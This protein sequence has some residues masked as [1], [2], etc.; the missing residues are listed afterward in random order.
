MAAK[1]LAPALNAVLGWPPPYAKTGLNAALVSI[2]A[3]NE[4]RAL[5]AVARAAQYE[6]WG[7]D[8]H[9][10][11]SKGTCRLCKAIWRLERLAR[12]SLPARSTVQGSAK[13]GSN[14][15]ASGRGSK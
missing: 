6:G 13:L 4:Y 10:E 3:R 2:Q 5:L 8:H 9:E 1:V 15:R 14:S 11:R 7:A 12:V